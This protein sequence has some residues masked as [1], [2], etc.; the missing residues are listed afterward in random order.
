[1]ESNAFKSLTH[2]SLDSQDLLIHANCNG[3]EFCESLLA[4]QIHSGASRQCATPNG[5]FGENDFSFGPLAHKSDSQ[6]VSTTCTISRFADDGHFGNGIQSS[7]KDLE[8]A[9]PSRLPR[10][11]SWPE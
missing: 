5:H 3:F 9:L 8:G 11:G 4:A 2:G 10:H 1:M 7:T 6:K